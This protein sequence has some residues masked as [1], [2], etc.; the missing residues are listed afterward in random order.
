MITGDPMRIRAAFPAGQQPDPLRP[1]SQ[2]CSSATLRGDCGDDWHRPERSLVHQLAKTDFG[3]G[4]EVRAELLDDTVVHTIPAHCSQGL[5]CR[6][7][8]CT[9]AEHGTRSGVLQIDYLTADRDP[10]RTAVG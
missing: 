10:P 3:I 7:C 9:R 4:R 5:K 6:T 2:I 1:A 8:L